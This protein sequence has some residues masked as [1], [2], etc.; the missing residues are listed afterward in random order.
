[1]SI[2]CRRAGGAVSCVPSSHIPRKSLGGSDTTIGELA[3]ESVDASVGTRAVPII[4]IA[5]IAKN[6]NQ[7]IIVCIGF[8]GLDVAFQGWVISPGTVQH[9]TLGFNPLIGFV[10]IVFR[11]NAL[12]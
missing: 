5:I 6:R 1:M 8:K 11:Q 3:N 10:T 2:V 12:N 9:H 4:M 7:F